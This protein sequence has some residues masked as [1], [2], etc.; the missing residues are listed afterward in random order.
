MS[1]QHVEGDQ[2]T[3]LE[4]SSAKRAFPNNAPKQREWV[5]ECGIG[6]MMAAEASFWEPQ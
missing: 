3:R 4:K 1:H 6:W 5:L 2:L